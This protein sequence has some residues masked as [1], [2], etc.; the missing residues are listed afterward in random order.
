MW[1]IAT[2]LKFGTNRLSTDDKKS[3]ERMNPPGYAFG[4]PSGSQQQQQ[5]R[6]RRQQQ[7]QGLNSPLFDELRREGLELFITD[8]T[9]EQA[10]QHRR[11]RTTGLICDSTVI[12]IAV[13]RADAEE[14]ER[15]ARPPAHSARRQRLA[16]QR[17]V[18]RHEALCHGAATAFESRRPQ[19]PSQAPRAR[20]ARAAAL[21]SAH[22]AAPSVRCR[23]RCPMPLPTAHS[24]SRSGSR[25]MGNNNN[26]VGQPRPLS[27][28]CL[29]VPCPRSMQQ[30]L[31][32]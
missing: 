27:L 4:P 2:M 25:P 30:H 8:H 19:R 17:H 11:K 29:R 26:N 1:T 31:V 22:F 5:Q 16:N 24:R 3:E 14:A 12:A 28:H 9:R 23:P 13:R 32:Q 15:R 7:Q 18:R 6:H 21:A 10:A 20:A